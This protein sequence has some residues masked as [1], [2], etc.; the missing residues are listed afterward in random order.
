MKAGQAEKVF[1][2]K[3]FVKICKK[4][5]NGAEISHER[6][7]EIGIEANAEEVHEDDENEELWVGPRQ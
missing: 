2:Q 7:E 4:D 1:M 3:G 5:K 6:A